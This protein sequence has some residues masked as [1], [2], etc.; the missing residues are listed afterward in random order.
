MPLPAASLRRRGLSFESL[1]ARQTIMNAHFPISLLALLCLLAACGPSSDRVRI[2]GDYRNI[3]SSEFYIYDESGQSG[4]PDTITIREGQFTFERPLSK[5]CV[6]TLLYPNFSEL[7][8]IAEPGK[9]ITVK[10][11][12][13]QLMKTR[14]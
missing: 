4:P 3:S 2:E 10:G 7:R 6:L 5:P 13:N 11:D 9:T 8:L 1:S 12:A 14:H